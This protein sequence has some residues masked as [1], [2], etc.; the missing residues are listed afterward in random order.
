MQATKTITSAKFENPANV[1]SLVGDDVEVT[2]VLVVQLQDS[3]PSESRLRLSKVRN[4][5]QRPIAA[6]SE[7]TSL[8]VNVQKYSLPPFRSIFCT[9]NSKADLLFICAV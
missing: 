2:T 9:V 3:H 8:N 7:W 6:F 1:E 5:F 4:W